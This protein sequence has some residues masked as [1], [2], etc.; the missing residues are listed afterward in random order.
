MIF[1]VDEVHELFFYN[2]CK[3]FTNDEYH[4]ALYYLLGATDTTRVQ[5]YNIYNPTER[6][7]NFS[8]LRKGWQTSGTIRIC[9]LAFNLFNGFV[10]KKDASL[11]TPYEIF[12]Y[13]ELAPVFLTAIRIRFNA[14]SN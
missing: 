3:Q 6:S 13:E 9:R 1:F 14:Q 4:R 12:N 8:C 7:I 2:C 10:V 5:F 11:Y